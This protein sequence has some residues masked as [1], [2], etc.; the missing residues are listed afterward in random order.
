MCDGALEP[1]AVC[2]TAIA[3]G[4]GQG[5]VRQRGPRYRAVRVC[6]GVR[7]VK[8]CVRSSVLEVGVRVCRVCGVH[9]SNDGVGCSSRILRRYAKTDVVAVHNLMNEGCQE[10]GVRARMQDRLLEAVGSARRA[11]EPPRKSSRRAPSPKMLSSGLAVP[12]ERAREEGAGREM[13]WYACS[14]NLVLSSVQLGGDHIGWQRSP[15]ITF[16]PG[17]K[18]T[19]A[20]RRASVGSVPGAPDV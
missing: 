18:A 20:P 12:A 16:C 1:V 6:W 13:K 7:G 3:G 10:E 2:P 9:R 19:G 4:T 15:G 5:R 17:T 8:L 14:Q 11:Q